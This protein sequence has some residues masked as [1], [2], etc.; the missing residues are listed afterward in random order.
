MEM[1]QTLPPLLLYNLIFVAPML[2]I[3]GV[4]YLGFKKVDDISAWKEKNITRLHLVAG[5]IMLVLGVAMILGW[6]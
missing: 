1:L 2:I 6:V 3:V 5:L 4:V